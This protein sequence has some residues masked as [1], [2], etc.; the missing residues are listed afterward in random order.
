MIRLLK[1]NTLAFLLYGSLLVTGTLMAISVPKLEL[2]AWMN[3]QHT[4]LLDTLFRGLTFL[5]DG[6]FAAILSVSF[7]LIKYRYAIM[8]ALASLASG[9]LVQF[10]KRVVFREMERPASFL[11]QMPDLGL[12]AGV[13]LHHHFSFPSGHTTTAFAILVLAGLISGKRWITFLLILLAWM[14]GLSRVYLSQHFLMDV[15]AGSLI[16]LLS[17]LLFY[18]YFQRINRQWL[19]KSIIRFR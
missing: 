9:F 4:D 13:D 2:H 1:D 17:A 5:G 14:V 3:A 12:V 11:D 18:W 19:E 10:F 7:L 15:L 6:W 16:G 8:T